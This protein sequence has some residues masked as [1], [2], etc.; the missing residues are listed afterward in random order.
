MKKIQTFI[1]LINKSLVKSA[2]NLS[3]EVLNL[4]IE[5]ITIAHSKEVSYCKILHDRLK[6]YN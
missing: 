5:M 1:Y 3:K 2:S 6:V 4:L